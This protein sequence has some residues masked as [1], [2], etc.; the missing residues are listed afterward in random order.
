MRL[1]VGEEKILLVGAVSIITPGPPSESM[2]LNSTSIHEFSGDWL[3]SVP[4]NLHLSL[5]KA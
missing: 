3:V 2:N 5:K 4:F 1:S